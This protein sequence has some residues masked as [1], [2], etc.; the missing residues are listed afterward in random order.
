MASGA[1][2]TSVSSEINV[3]PPVRQISRVQ[4]GLLQSWS[5]HRVRLIDRSDTQRSA[6][7]GFSYF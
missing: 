5:T 1:R 4:R 2:V 7:L 6:L 3:M